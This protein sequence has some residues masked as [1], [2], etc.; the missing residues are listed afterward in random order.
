[1]VYSRR[2][3]MVSCFHQVLASH[4][5]GGAGHIA[6]GLASELQGRGQVSHV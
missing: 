3:K 2:S 5:L 1:M 6:L 4:E